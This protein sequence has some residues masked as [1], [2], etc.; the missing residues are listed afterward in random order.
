MTKLLS[1]RTVRDL[2]SSSHIFLFSIMKSILNNDCFL[3]IKIKSIRFIHYPIRALQDVL[4]Y[5]FQIIEIQ[6]VNIIKKNSNFFNCNKKIQ[7]YNWWLLINYDTAQQGNHCFLFFFNFRKCFLLTV[8][9]CSRYEVFSFWAK[10]F[11][12]L[13][14]SKSKS[15]GFFLD[16][17]ILIKL[18]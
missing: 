1:I 13:S 10:I 12:M 6:L 3:L 7:F 4:Y 17:K 14:S 15:W 18:C 16:D 9:K 2:S 11:F 5:I 8:R